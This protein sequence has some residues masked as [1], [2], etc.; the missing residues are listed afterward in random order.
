MTWWRRLRLRA[1]SPGESATS[2][3]PAAGPARAVIAVHR[4]EPRGS[5]TIRFAPTVGSHD[6]N[7]LGRFL[8]VARRGPVLLRPGD[9]TSEDPRDMAGLAELTVV[10]AGELA[11][12][13]SLGGRG[14]LGPGAVRLVAGGAGI[15][16]E[17]VLSRDLLRDGGDVDVLVV[18]WRQPHSVETDARTIPTVRIA[19]RA[20]SLR[21]GRS[22]VR[23]IVGPAGAVTSPTGETV[24]RVT[25][26]P[27]AT[28]DLPLPPRTG[29]ALVVLLSGTALIGDD[30][31]QV[32]GPA[33]AVLEDGGPRL[34]VATHLEGDSEAELV[35][36]THPA[37]EDPAQAP[38]LR[39]GDIVA[40][41]E[42]AMA[43]A[44]EAARSGA[45][46]T[47]PRWSG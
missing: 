11:H 39:R 29:A 12:R 20:P 4:A 35:V 31:R 28:V 43:A 19:E 10:E 46:G 3:P 26:A 27:G 25:V 34:M 33:L 9:G 36:L 21:Q 40:A 45:F 8:D 32:R 15:A 6:S 47:L 41:D 24:E 38:P 14:L 2:L 30:L 7:D 44:I 13:D 23:R 17:A 18:R 16:S 5:A 1:P 42:A 22:V 37:D